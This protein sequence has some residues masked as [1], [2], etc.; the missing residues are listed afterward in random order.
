MTTLFKWVVSCLLFL[1]RYLFNS[2]RLLYRWTKCP[3]IHLSTSIQRYKWLHRLISLFFDISRLI[4]IIIIWLIRIS[5]F[6]LR[7]F[8]MIINECREYLMTVP[9]A[10][11][12]QLV[13]LCNN[14]LH[15]LLFLCYPLLSLVE[16]V[17]IESRI[18][19][20]ETCSRFYD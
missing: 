19:K 20:F 11:I 5:I 4:P 15:I 7:L 12:I 6:D 18:L 1:Y 13:L 14:L 17:P 10:V 8:I 3:I 9:L 2:L 16:P